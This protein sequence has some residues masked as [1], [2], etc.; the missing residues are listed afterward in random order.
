MRQVV[1]Y[2]KV[3]HVRLADAL[4]LSEFLHS[5]RTSCEPHSRQLAWKVPICMPLILVKELPILFKLAS[6]PI[7]VPRHSRRCLSAV[8][9]SAGSAKVFLDLM[10]VCRQEKRSFASGSLQ[11]RVIMS[12]DFV[13]QMVPIRSQLVV[14]ECQPRPTLTSTSCSVQ[15]T[16]GLA[17]LKAEAAALSLPKRTPC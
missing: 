8:L 15:N 12:D 14:A 16:A 6:A 13:V 4:F 11:V 17:R 10:T 1:K 2:A 3:L 7:S 5:S 9:Q